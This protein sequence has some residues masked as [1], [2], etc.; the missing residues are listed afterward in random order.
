MD[1]DDLWQDAEDIL[2]DALQWTHHGP[3]NWATVEAQ[4]QNLHT[5]I[6]HNDQHQIERATIELEL[7]SPL[8]CWPPHKDPDATAIPTTTAD[9]ISQ[10]QAALAATRPRT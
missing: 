3:R 8:R 10:T 4:V 9:L 1:N 2:S 5:G 7:L 6:S